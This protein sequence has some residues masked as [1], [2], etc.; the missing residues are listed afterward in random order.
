LGG[1]KLRQSP[2]HR[3]TCA[4]G[5]RSVDLQAEGRRG[6]VLYKSAALGAGCRPAGWSTAA[7]VPPCGV[8]PTRWHRQN[9]NHGRMLASVMAM[10]RL[11]SPRADTSVACWVGGWRGGGGGGRA[12]GRGGPTRL[13][14]P[15]IALPSDT[16][17]QTAWITR[18]CLRK[19]CHFRRAARRRY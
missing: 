19:C 6:G 10:L 11:A 8:P 17:L 9:C 5:K 16:E 3:Q 1:Q 12:P 18:W 7:S 13:P 4:H 2:Q 15:Q 14:L